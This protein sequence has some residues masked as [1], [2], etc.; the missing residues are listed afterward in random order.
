MDVETMAICWVSGWGLTSSVSKSGPVKQQKLDMSEDPECDWNLTPNMLCMSNE[1][2]A[3]TGCKGDSGGPLACQDRKSKVWILA[4]AVSFG[5]SECSGATVFTR[6]SNYISWVKYQTAEAGRPFIP[7][8]SKGAA[9][10]VNQKNTSPVY[11]PKVEIIPQAVTVQRPQPPYGQVRSMTNED[12]PTSGRV[13][14]V[15]WL[16]VYYL[17]MVL[18]FFSMN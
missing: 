1:D 18:Y 13:T 8:V 5:S 12:Q 7:Y 3:R 10:E 4:G 17:S 6:L 14:V 2:P 9:S 11:L 16:L 15:P